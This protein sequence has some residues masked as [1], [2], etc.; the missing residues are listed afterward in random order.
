MVMLQVSSGGHNDDEGN[1]K[2][3]KHCLMSK[4]IKTLNM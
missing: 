1:E 3:K 4:Q 2:I